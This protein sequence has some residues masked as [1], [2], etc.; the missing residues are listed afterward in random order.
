M[1]NIGKMINATV[2]GYIMHIQWIYSN[3]R[4][5]LVVVCQVFGFTKWK[6][7]NQATLAEAY[8]VH[9]HYFVYTIDYTA[10][11]TCHDIY[12][13]KCVTCSS[14]STINDTKAADAKWTENWLEDD[15]HLQFI[16]Y[17]EQHEKPKRAYS[18]S[19]MN[20]KFGFDSY[21]LEIGRRRHSAIRV[22]T[23]FVR[24]FD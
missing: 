15:K 11:A 9:R 23:G 12:E 17:S 21:Y 18:V 3:W 6:W 14:S 10:F 7:I 5:H 20:H 16:L 4:K 8:N 24:E 19:V 2:F 1:S 22:C 13:M